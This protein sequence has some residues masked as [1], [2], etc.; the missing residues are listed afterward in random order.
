MT[1]CRKE[2]FKYH[3][4]DYTQQELLELEQVLKQNNNNTLNKFI[5]DYY[6]LRENVRKNQ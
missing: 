1:S 3:L 4:Q 2:T 6:N 5:I